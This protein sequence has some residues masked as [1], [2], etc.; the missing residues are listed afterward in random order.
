MR[1]SGTET[2][3]FLDYVTVGG[4]AATT[5]AF[6]SAKR[7]HT[8]QHDNDGVLI[9]PRRLSQALRRLVPVTHWH[10]AVP[11]AQEMDSH[12]STGLMPNRQYV[13]SGCNMVGSVKVEGASGERRFSFS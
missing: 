4:F 8:G 9:A 12:K 7:P 11:Q 2:I 5:A 13:S 3:P 1:I 6:S 10:L